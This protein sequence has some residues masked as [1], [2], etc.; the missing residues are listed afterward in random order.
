MGKRRWSQQYAH[1]PRL[2]DD[3]IIAEGLRRGAFKPESVEA[4]RE[5]A[6]LSPHPF[7]SVDVLDSLEIFS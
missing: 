6:R 4:A 1:I 7:W 2:I 3:Y 5:Q